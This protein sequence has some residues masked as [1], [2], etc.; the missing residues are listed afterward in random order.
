M[1]FALN[2][3]EAFAN[4]DG[5]RANLE[6]SLEQFARFCVAPVI[7][8]IESSFNAELK[9][10]FETA[11]AIWVFE[12]VIPEDDNFALEEEKVKVQAGRSPG[13]MGM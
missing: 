1:M 3:P 11:N 8:L 7:A 12:N 10:E 2:V 6:G 13:R 9:S 4:N 5:N